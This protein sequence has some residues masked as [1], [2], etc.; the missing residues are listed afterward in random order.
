[1]SQQPSQSDASFAGGLVF[2]LLVGAALVIVLSP[3]FRAKVSSTA[4]DLGI[5]TPQTDLPAAEQKSEQLLSGVA[6][7]A[8]PLS[9]AESAS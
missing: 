8:D 7:P 3:E 6:P 9:R 4:Q 2:G 5:Y 1:M